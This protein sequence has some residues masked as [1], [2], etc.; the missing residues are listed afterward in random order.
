L[1]EMAPKIREAGYTPLVWG[2]QARNV[3]PDFFL[4]LVTQY[5]GDVLKMDDTGTGWDSEPVSMPSIC[6]T[7]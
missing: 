1:I 4:P 7:G 6:S 5:G 3:C 2:N